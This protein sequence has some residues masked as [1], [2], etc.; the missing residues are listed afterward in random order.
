M[1]NNVV[2]ANVQN[3]KDLFMGDLFLR[4]PLGFTD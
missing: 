1:T 4:N 2:N 3:F